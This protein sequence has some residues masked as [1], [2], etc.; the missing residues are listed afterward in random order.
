[1]LNQILGLDKDEKNPK[2]LLLLALSIL[3]MGLMA[4]FKAWIIFLVLYTFLLFYVVIKL[5]IKTNYLYAATLL[6]VMAQILDDLYFFFT[7]STNLD[8]LLGILVYTGM[9]VNLIVLIA[10][11]YRFIKKSDYLANLLFILFNLLVVA[12]IYFISR[13]HT[14][15]YGSMEKADGYFMYVF[16]TWIVF[17]IIVVLSKRLLQGDNKVIRFFQS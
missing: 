9:F 14:L 16:F 11:V 13:T 15:S 4:L 2:A 10:G 8:L 17:F 7:G 1:M 6:I 5:V 3:T 12:A